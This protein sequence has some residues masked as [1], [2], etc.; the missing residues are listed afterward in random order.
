[1]VRYKQTTHGQSNNRNHL[2]FN[3]SSGRDICQKRIKN[4]KKVVKNMH[5]RFLAYQPIQLPVDSEIIDIQPARST[6]D[7]MYMWY[8]CDPKQTAVEVHEFEMYFTD[9]LIDYTPGTFR[10]HVATLQERGKQVH[11]FELLSKQVKN[12]QETKA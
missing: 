1:M 9:Q 8:L 5:L 12:E 7:S 3:T 2:R 4:M 10:K 11:I 6:I